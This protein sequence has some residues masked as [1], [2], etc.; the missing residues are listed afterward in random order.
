MNAEVLAKLAGLLITYGP[1]L[2]DAAETIWAGIMQ[3]RQN[4]ERAPTD[5]ELAE[6]VAEAEANHASLPL[7]EDP[8]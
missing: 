3:I 5:V 4:H 7:P 8:G 2:I 1:G 6:L